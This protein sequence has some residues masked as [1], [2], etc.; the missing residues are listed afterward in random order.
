MTARITPLSRAR[1][2]RNGHQDRPARTG[3]QV[4]SALAA[5]ARSGGKVPNGPGRIRRCSDSFGGMPW[6]VLSA[7]AGLGHKRASRPEERPCVEAITHLLLF[8]G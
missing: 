5:Q 2:G 3:I 4:I 6:P 8:G 7:E 1:G